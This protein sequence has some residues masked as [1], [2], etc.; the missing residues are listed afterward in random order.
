MVN[1]WNIC[2][3]VNSI[4][5]ILL[6]IFDKEERDRTDQYI[7]KFKDDFKN[8][9]SEAI[10]D[11]IISN[12]LYLYFDET[13]GIIPYAIETVHAN[14]Q[15]YDIVHDEY[16]RYYKDVNPYMYGTYTR[17]VGTGIISSA[18]CTA[19]VLFTGWGSAFLSTIYKY[20]SIWNN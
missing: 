11:L 4:V 9:N 2:D 19:D 15:Y 14:R 3:C 1:V 5:G 13:S 12:D 6:K 7:D 20:V 18:S 10:I 16:G 17:N 8:N